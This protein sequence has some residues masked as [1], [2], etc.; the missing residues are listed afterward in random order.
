MVG[1]AGATMARKVKGRPGGGRDDV[2]VKI[3][4]ALAYKL[5]AIATHK[6]VP[7][8][9]ILSEL[10]EGPVDRAYLRML[11]DLES[12]GEGEVPKGKGKPR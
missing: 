4:R 11:K 6:G 5:K 9:A 2:P 8:A 10:A 3:D 7:L 1:I 12:K